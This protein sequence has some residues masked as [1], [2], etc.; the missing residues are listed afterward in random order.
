MTKTNMK[1]CVGKKNGYDIYRTIYTID[2]HYYVKWNNEIINVDED[3]KNH[4]YT[5]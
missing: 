5:F 2:N 4:N 3:V 1:T